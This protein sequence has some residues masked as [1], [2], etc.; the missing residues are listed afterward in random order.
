MLAQS[1]A[2]AQAFVLLRLSAWANRQVDFINQ[3]KKRV[4]LPDGET[5]LFCMTM[6]NGR[7]VKKQGRIRRNTSKYA[8]FSVR[9]QFLQSRTGVLSI[10]I[11]QY[12]TENTPVLE[13]K[14]SST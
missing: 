13:S 2:L 5:P 7:L 14:Y 12:G 3:R 9:P 11:L 10:E 1:A 4:G 6:E 8:T